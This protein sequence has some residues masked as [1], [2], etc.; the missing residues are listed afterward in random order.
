MSKKLLSFHHER[1]NMKTNILTL[2]FGLMVLGVLAAQNLTD[3][4]TIPK[5]GESIDFNKA[6]SIFRKQSGWAK[7]PQEEINY[8]M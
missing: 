6:H 5:S 1:Y 4:T 8:L 2:S 7:L 3:K